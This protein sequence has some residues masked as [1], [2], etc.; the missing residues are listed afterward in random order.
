MKT[1]KTDFMEDIKDQFEYFKENRQFDQIAGLFTYVLH[2]KLYE[3]F[4]QVFGY[5]PGIFPEME[6]LDAGKITK[7]D[8]C[9]GEPVVYKIHYGS[10]QKLYDIPFFYLF[11]YFK[12]KPRKLNVFFQSADDEFENLSTGDYVLSKGKIRFGGCLTAFNGGD[13]SVISVSDPGHFVPGLTSGYYAGSRE[14][15]FARLIAGVLE[16]LCTLAGVHLDQTLLFGS[17][18]GSMGALLCSTW[19]SRKVNVMA[20]N[21]QINIQHHNRL[22]EVLFGMSDPE[23]LVKHYGNQV[24]CSHRFQQELNSVPNIYI[25]ANVNNELYEKNWEFYRMYQERFTARGMDN[26]SVFDSYYG[27]EGHGFP[28]RS[29]LRTKI[30]IAREVLTM[31]SVDRGTHSMNG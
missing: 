18:A 29:A 15:D 14:I 6:I 3:S 10:G 22:M 25:L 13:V 9:I 31:K 4:K 8:L 2:N 30:R 28:S 23:K 12:E 19:F 27:I 17:S 20:V 1:D 16:T 21:S 11:C 24:S 7:S 26:Q 5:I